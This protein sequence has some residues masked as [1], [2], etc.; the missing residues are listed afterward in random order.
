[1]GGIP[2]VNGRGERLL[3]HIGIIDILQSYRC[4]GHAHQVT[5]TPLST[6]PHPSGYLAMPTYSLFLTPA[7]PVFRCIWVPPRLTLPLSVQ[8]SGFLQALPLRLAL[9][10][11]ADS[12]GPI[13]HQVHQ[14]VRTHLEGPRP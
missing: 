1:M 13:C 11:W 5:L 3:L 6:W 8:R 4:A 2:A 14:E 9:G 7:H 10:Q 12:L